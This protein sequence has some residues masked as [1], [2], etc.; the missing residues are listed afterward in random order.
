MNGCVTL[1]NQE[2]LFSTLESV[3]FRYPSEF[4]GS[5]FEKARENYD[6]DLHQEM[7]K[8]RDHILVLKFGS[9]ATLSGGVPNYVTHGGRTHH[10]N[11]N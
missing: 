9:H 8:P 7:S 1:S 3:H 10:A 5:L 4:V 11:Q 6:F 2:N